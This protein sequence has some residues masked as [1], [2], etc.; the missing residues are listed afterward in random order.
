M[1]LV[2]LADA[3]DGQE[4]LEIGL[5]IVNRGVPEIDEGD[6]YEFLITGGT[7]S[8]K[9]ETAILE[10]AKDEFIYTGSHVFTHRNSGQ[11]PLVKF[12]LHRVANPIEFQFEECATAK[13]IGGEDR[14]RRPWA[15]SDW[16]RGV[17]LALLGWRGVVAFASF[18]FGLTLGFH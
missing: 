18:Y 17:D 2:K 4:P 10:Q 1:S 3:F 9:R 12:R 16:Q 6:P 14:Y 8:P 15:G 5:S 11:V 13:R 7:E